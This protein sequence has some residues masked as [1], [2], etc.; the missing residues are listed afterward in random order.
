MTVEEGIKSRRSVRKFTDKKVDKETI[1]AIIET[2]RFSPSW[3]NSQTPRYIV[4]ENESVKNKIAEECVL[5][6]AYNEKNIKACKSL[7]IVSYVKDI[8]GF[9]KDG[10]YS[11]PKGDHWEMFDA[12]IATQ[13][14][15]LAAHEKGVG[16]V[17]LGVFD[18][19]KVAEA[20][21]LPS[22]Q[23]VAAL[24]PI[25]YSDGTP[26]APKRKEVDEILSFIE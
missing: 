20:I 2:C 22:D 13:S 23:K 16:T 9:E 14:F 5:N 15:C 25:G 21:S 12:G 17:I 11:T 6:F 3:K 26:A 1:E 24:I 4:I 8:C 18:D 7:V 19:A 10:S